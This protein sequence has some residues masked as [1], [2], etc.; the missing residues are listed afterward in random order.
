M[1]SLYIQKNRG[2]K[3]SIIR[4]FNNVMWSSH[5]NTK[6]LL[7]MKN[8]RNGVSQV[9]PAISEGQTPPPRQTYSTKQFLGLLLGPILFFLILYALPL[10]GLSNEGRGVFATIVLVAT[11]W[12]LEVM[13]LGIT[14]LLPIVLLPLLTDVTG[15]EAASSYGDPLNFLFL[16]GFAIALALERWRLHERIAITVIGIIGTSMSGLV[17]GFML[18]TGFI[19]MWVSNTATAL[20]MIPIGTAIATKVIDLMKE[21]N[22]YTP[23]EDTKFTKS[24]I[25]AIGFGATIGGSATLI[26]TPSNLILAGLTKEIL[27]IDI[28]FAKW[29]IFAFPMIVILMASAA[30]Y[31]TKFAYPM[32]V[33]KLE[34]GHIFVMETKKELGKMSY[35]EKMVLTVFLL[36]AFMWLTRTFIWV[37]YIP[38]L[39]DTIIAITGAVLLYLIPT[40]RGDNGRLLDGSS[41]KK[42][43][44]DVLLLVG[45]GLAIAT[46]FSKTD[47]AV[48]SGDQLLALE[49]TSYITILAIT[50]A[51]GILMTQ[52]TPNTATATILIPIAATLAVA[53]Q[54]D[55]LPVMTATALGTGFA[56]MM[57]ISTPSNAIIFATGKITFTDMIRKGAWLTALT[58]VLII[59][60]V[61]FLFPIVF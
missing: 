19:S 25:F 55:P 43:P 20:L 29:F 45:G 60:F 26:G 59:L 8:V 21:E 54:V 2:K 4:R 18:A 7:T 36:T 56:Y 13:P 10:E 27:G 57:P 14:S 28:S 12:I 35:E 40:K 11:W 15:K 50:T 46:G 24:I 58:L 1:N 16:G 3:M 41:I 32:K 33:K 49:G 42:M 48:W 23:E 52:V 47:L 38:A 22:V 9:S 6:D 5:H 31:I 39:T 53:I 51:I 34:K 17:I 44:W 37:N 61:Y 30:F